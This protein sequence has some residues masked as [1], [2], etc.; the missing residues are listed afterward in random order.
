[1]GRMPSPSSK[2]LRLALPFTVLSGGD[3]VHLVA[4]EDFRYTLSAPGLER[5][6]PP[7]LARLDGRRGLDELLEAVE[8]PLREAARALLERLYGERVLVEGSAEGA[9][10]PARLAIA[11]EGQGALL[12]ALRAAAEPAPA[13]GPGLPVLCQDRLDYDAALRFDARCRTAG[14]RWLW[15]TT[16]PMER[17]YVGPLFLPDAGPCLQCLLGGFVRLSPAPEL[18]AALI[19][20]A[21]RGSPIRPVPFPAEGVGILAHLVRWKASLLE[22]P[23]PPAALYRLH[24]LE[25]GTMELSAHAVLVDPLCPACGAGP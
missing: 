16:G 17:A 13:G 12:E 21:R 1:M 7:L 14:L 3:A 19:E 23:E 5:W 24:V 11:P 9:H 20:H 15:A 2:R 22:L 6:L 4:G 25:A 10:R 18:Y 8:P